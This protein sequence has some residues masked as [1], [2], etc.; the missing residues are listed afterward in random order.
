MDVYSEPAKSIF[1]IFIGFLGGLAIIK[2][3]FDFTTQSF[4][5]IKSLAVAI[6]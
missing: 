2:L 5:N 1:T 6:F 3:L 4:G